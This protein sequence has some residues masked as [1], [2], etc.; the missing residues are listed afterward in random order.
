M[1]VEA[2]EIQTHHK[3]LEPSAGSGA[4]V[5]YISS[6]YNIQPRDIDCVELNKEKYEILRSKHYN[7]FHW[8]FLSFATDK[9]YH[10]KY[11]RIIAC[12]PFKKNIDIAHIESMYGLLKTGGI[13]VSLTSPLWITNNEEHQV[14]FREWLADKDYS[15]KML[16]ENSYIEDY[17][18]VPTM[19]IKIY[20]K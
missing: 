6:N 20:K 8:E 15:M 17:K 12:P 18:S 1:L 10:E 11:D 19:I 16:P 14:K 4:I 9:N 3:I 13:L 5:D 2:A 7:S